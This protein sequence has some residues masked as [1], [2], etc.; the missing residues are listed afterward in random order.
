LIQRTLAY[1]EALAR[2]HQ[3]IQRNAN[4][5]L[6]HFTEQEVVD[7]LDQ[8]VYR[9][10]LISDSLLQRFSRR[11]R[12]TDISNMTFHDKVFIVLKK[13]Q[14]PD[15]KKRYVAAEQFMDKLEFGRELEC[16][17]TM[18]ID[19][20]ERLKAIAEFQSGLDS[21]FTLFV[22]NPFDTR[23]F[24]SRILNNVKEKAG[25]RL[26]DHY[27]NEILQAKSCM[28][29]QVALDKIESLQAL[30]MEVA[31]KH[32]DAEVIELNRALRRETV[33]SRIERML[34]LQN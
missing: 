3:E 6:R 13:N 27:T 4:R 25:R 32:N 17:Y 14:V 11:T 5:E 18:I 21:L 29:A 34:G 1:M 22:E 20:R 28:D 8:V 10:E 26:I 16:F 30:L 33:P 9:N 7:S 19:D 15:L 2:K 24:E 23:Y 12:D 31:K